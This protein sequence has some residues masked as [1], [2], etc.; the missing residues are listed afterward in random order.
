M[1]EAEVVAVVVS[2]AEAS[3]GA[4]ST[5]LVV[6]LGDVSAVAVSSAVAFGVG[7]LVGATS[8]AIFAITDSLTM[9][10]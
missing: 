6:S 8:V 3:A 4:L 1:A 10:S 5:A 7:V 2:T 9:S